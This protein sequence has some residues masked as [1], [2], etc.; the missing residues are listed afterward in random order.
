MCL[1]HKKVHSAMIFSGFRSGSSLP[2][3]PA[4]FESQWKNIRFTFNI[5]GEKGNIFCCLLDWSPSSIYRLSSR[6][7]DFH[8]EE[9]K[10]PQ[11]INLWFWSI[12][13]FSERKV[14][15]AKNFIWDGKTMLRI[16]WDNIP[17]ILVEKERHVLHSRILYGPWPLTTPFWR[18][19]GALSQGIS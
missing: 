12:H 3:W 15:Q 11:V 9:K 18:I 13:T 6:V 10:K 19:L 16:M 4:Y 14:G 17:E 1:L 2:I 5:P 8:T 7:I